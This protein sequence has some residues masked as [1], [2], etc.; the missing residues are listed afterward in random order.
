MKRIIAALLF[1]ALAMPQLAFGWGREGHQIIAAVSEHHLNE[2]TKVM[3]QSLI[4]NNHLYSIAS[5]A[6]EIRNQRRGTAAWH[7]VKI[8]PGSEYQAA[9]DC[10]PPK[11]CVV[12]EIEDLI[13]VLTDKKAPREERAEALKFLVHF[14]GDIH[15]PMH[16][17]GEAAGGNGIHVSFLENTRCGPYDCN[18]HVVWDTSMIQRTGMNRDVYVEHEEALLKSERLARLDGGIPMQW[19]NESAHLA[20]TAWVGNETNLDDNYY[21]REIKV[22]DRQMALAGL[23][24]AKLLNDTIGRMTPRDFASAQAATSDPPLITSEA[25]TRISTGAGNPTFMP[26]RKINECYRDPNESLASLSN[27]DLKLPFKVPTSMINEAPN[28]R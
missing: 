8:P 25:S 3:I 11:S 10:A 26:P 6:D 19:A 9:R 7:Y 28:G 2:T 20:Q 13:K 5:W 4:G 15:Q 22:V 1:I 23:R 21:Q 14:V 18:L 24:L 17:V 12:A 27:C 16:A